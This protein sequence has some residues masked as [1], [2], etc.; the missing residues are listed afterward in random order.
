LSSDGK[1]HPEAAVAWAK[2]KPESELY[3]VIEWD[4]AKAADA[5]RIAQV[6]GL[7][8][9]VVV[10][11]KETARNVRAYLSQPSDRAHG[12]GYRKMEDAL[13]AARQELVNDALATVERI[14]DRFTHLPELAS[15]FLE[16]D[17]AVAGF[18]IEVANKKAA[19]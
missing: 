5:H 14:K 7:I 4:D 16:I 9:I 2:G 17:R 3:S 19:G 12:G 10:Q 1:L 13:A 8:R 18:R 15:L 11:S 6:R